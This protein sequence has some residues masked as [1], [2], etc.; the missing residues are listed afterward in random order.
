MRNRNDG[1]LVAATSAETSELGL[2]V[3]ALRFDRSSR[4][5]HQNR[6]Q[7]RV[8]FTRRDVLSLSSAFVVAGTESSPCSDVIVIDPR[9]HVVTDL[10]EDFDRGVA[11][12]TRHLIEPAN[13]FGVRLGEGE[14]LRLDLRSSLLQL[15]VQ[16]QLML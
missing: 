5:L 3:A 14:R 7:K 2:V 8:A 6:F 9:R 15:L 4:R 10:T 16:N 12:D 11:I 1:A 13:E